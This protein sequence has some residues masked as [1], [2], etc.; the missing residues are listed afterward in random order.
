MSALFLTLLSACSTVPEAPVCG[1]PE[2]P[3]APTTTKGKDPYA[4]VTTVADLADQVVKTRAALQVCW[5]QLDAVDEWKKAV[6]A[7]FDDGENDR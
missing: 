3:P 7:V 1:K 2:L 5:K 6:T 4:P